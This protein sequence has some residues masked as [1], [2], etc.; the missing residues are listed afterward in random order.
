M[1]FAST[2]K[3]MMADSLQNSTQ[4]LEFLL[5]VRVFRQI[6]AEYQPR[7][8]GGKSCVWFLVHCETRVGYDYHNR[9]IK[10]VFV[11]SRGYK[12]RGFVVGEKLTHFS[13]LIQFFF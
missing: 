9:T 2:R 13:S 11:L 8:S 12:I 6:V 5:K 10:C 3:L 7:K 4:K 1:G